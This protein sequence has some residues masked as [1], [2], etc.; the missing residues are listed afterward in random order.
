MEI[1]KASAISHSTLEMITCG[2]C[3]RISDFAI[4]FTLSRLTTH[5]HL[6]LRE[7]CAKVTAVPFFHYR[8]Q[9]STS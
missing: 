3:A 7:A 4:R 5:H 9:V 6:L 2:H 8:Q 1:I